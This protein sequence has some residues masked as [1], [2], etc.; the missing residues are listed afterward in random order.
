MVYTT[1]IRFTLFK[2]FHAHFGI[3]WPVTAK[4]VQVISSVG[5]RR[6]PLS[7]GNFEWLIQYFIANFFMTLCE[8]LLVFEG[9]CNLVVFDVPYITAGYG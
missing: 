6:I 5:A 4:V 2:G 8:L 7:K 9:L 1:T 3:F